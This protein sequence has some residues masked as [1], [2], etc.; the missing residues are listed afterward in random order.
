MYLP[1]AICTATHIR[2]VCIKL[3]TRTHACTHRHTDTHTHTHR[4][5]HTHTY[6]HGVTSINNAPI[7][8]SSYS[9][10]TGIKHIVYNK[11]KI[12]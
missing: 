2:H 4:H 3:H 6:T 5:T 8:A 10:I 9:K 12:Y 11:V 1:V 7:L